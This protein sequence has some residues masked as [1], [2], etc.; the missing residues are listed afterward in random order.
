M[1]KLVSAGNLALLLAIA[2]TCLWT[3]WGVTEMFHEGWY[4]PWEW[5]F[6]LLP[7]G[8]CLALTLVALTWRRL[9]GW[10]LIITGT[11]FY[12]WVMWSIAR[13][14]GLS[15]SAAL[16]WLPVSGVLALVGCL[17]LLGARE[18]Q[19]MGAPPDARWWR[20][21]LH[22][23]LAVGVPLL[24]GLG[25]AVEPAVRVAQRV[26]DGD[27][28]A[29]LIAGNGVA[30]LWAPQGPGWQSGVTWN[31]IA[32][33]GLPPVGFAGKAAGHAGQCDRDSSAG[34]AAA[35]EMQHYNVCLYLS[36]DGSRLESTPQGYWRMPTTDEVVRSL[37]W[38]GA[39]AGCLWNG[40]S[41]K[42]PC[43]V[44]PDKE[45]PLWNPRSPLIYLWT[46]DEA[47]AAEAYYVTYYGS[48]LR[49]AKYVGLGSQGYRCVHRMD[50]S[51]EGLR[52]LPPSPQR[53][54]RR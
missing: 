2:V 41:G 30:L 50:L 28:G 48:V 42:Q 38:H 34:C 47:N 11:G 54:Q 22:Y 1:K 17:F 13:R 29:R 33:Y 49:A 45:T 8:A 25:V 23:L 40:Q 52:V 15:L 43:A 9:G 5:L 31:E 32:L 27:Y 7:A 10:L 6:F 4:R 24:L 53:A 14:F 16:S 36:A 18:R 26:D 12:A 3:F 51:A 44:R 46:A 35:E 19:A 21:N 39:H 37:V 20:R